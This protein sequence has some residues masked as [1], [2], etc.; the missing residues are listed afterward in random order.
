MASVADTSLDNAIDE[1]RPIK[2]VCIGAGFSGILCGIRLPQ[3][4]SK[5]DLTIYEKNADFG[6]TWLENRYPG[7]GCDVP[8]HSYQYTFAPNPNWSMFYSGGA[9]IHEYLK[10]VAWRYD[11]AKYVKFQHVFQGATWNDATHQWNMKILDAQSGMAFD[12]TA[13]V[14]IRGTGLLNKWK[15]PD[16][17]GLHSFKGSLM[18]TANFDP[19]FDWTDKT[20]ALIG[21][22]STGIQVLPHIQP[23]AKHVFH[24]IR[25][26]TWISPVGYGA[27]IGGGSNFEYTIT[28][29]RNFENN[30]CL[31][32]EYRHKLEA[33]MNQSQI[34][35]FRGTATQKRFWEA[36][37]RFMKA[38]L[39]ERPEIYESLRPPFPPGCRR[40]TPGPGYLEALLQKNVTFIG[41]GVAEVDEKSIL[42]QQGNYHEVDA[43]ICA[44][45]FDYTF[46]N[47]TAPIIGRNGVSLDD[48]Y[49]P[50]PQAYM[51]V[52]VPN[53]PNHFMFLG[54]AS[55]PASGS[56]I[57][58][59]ELV[60][61]YIIQ[62]I[63]KLQMESYGWMEPTSEAL[64]HF[65][66]QADKYFQKT[67]FTYKC[68]SFFKGDQDEGRVSVVW[69]GS[70][71]HYM[72]AM[73]NPRWEDYQYGLRREAEGN[74]MSW[75]GN[76]LTVAQQ[77]KVPEVSEAMFDIKAVVSGLPA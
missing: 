50:F 71:A 65:N 53:M 26:K 29:R 5:L 28:E 41:S 30:P 63:S 62:C 75:L 49:T 45:G 54:P 69:P 3:R 60:M 24:Y 51:G 38:K 57:P 4:L 9:E 46:K 7:V 48:M 31:Y 72:K 35:T 19:T 1:V 20:V 74:C 15:W 59:L 2:V 37:D 44:T 47:A 36:T 8:S 67:V 12:D 22:G 42:D 40:L 17:K 33:A 11:V 66:V 21:A 43:I 68:N 16:I 14:L 55:A 25:G 34:V 32:L 61:D 23:E 39:A 18:H 52:A 10:D 58:T 56:F 27:D 70:A 64:Q 76:G 77:G 13:D 6:G 73:K